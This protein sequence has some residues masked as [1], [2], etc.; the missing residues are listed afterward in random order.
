ML[1]LDAPYYLNEQEARPAVGLEVNLGLISLRAGY[2][3][4]SDLEEFSVGTGFML[5]RSSLDYSYGLVEELDSQHRVS[6]SMRFGQSQSRIPAPFVKKDK[7]SPSLSGLLLKKT[8]DE[9]KSMKPNLL[10]GPL[11]I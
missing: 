1:L 4:G 6:L 7:K 8:R 5:G 10:V 9:E 2:K 11:A 3:S